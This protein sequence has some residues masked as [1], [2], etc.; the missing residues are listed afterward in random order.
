ML[1][2]KYARFSAISKDDF[3]E[4]LLFKIEQNFGIKKQL[5]DKS[6]ALFHSIVTVFREKDKLTTRELLLKVEGIYVPLLVYA[7]KLRHLA[8]TSQYIY[9][10]LCAHLNKKATDWDRLVQAY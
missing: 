5:E 6:F 3:A 10:S 2:N 8:S 7:G 4:E 1:L 9:K